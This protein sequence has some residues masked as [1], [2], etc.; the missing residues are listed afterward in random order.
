MKTTDINEIHAVLKRPDILRTISLVTTHHAASIFEAA[1]FLINTSTLSEKVGGEI[2]GRLW[3]I[4]ITKDGRSFAMCK[5]LPEYRKGYAKDFG[6]QSLYFKGHSTTLCRDTRQT[7]RMFLAFA[8]M[9]G[10]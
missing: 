10:F 6:E 7:I 2:I 9:N 1:L 5:F 8:K 4:M 3:Y